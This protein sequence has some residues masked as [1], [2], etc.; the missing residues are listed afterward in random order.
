[1]IL[2]DLYKDSSFLKDLSDHLDA[3]KA[4]V[5]VDGLTGSLPAVAIAALALRRPTVNQLV[6][7]PSK[8]EAY[9]LQNDIEALLQ[10]LPA[11]GGNPGN[12]ENGFDKISQDFDGPD[13]SWIAT[14]HLSP[15]T[16]H[17]P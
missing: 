4:R 1:M 3:A 13:K 8:E 11:S 12:P 2:T 16:F 17:L 5:H 14:F 9:Y 6:I 15:L 7:A 10:N